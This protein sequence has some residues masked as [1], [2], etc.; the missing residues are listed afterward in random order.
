LLLWPAQLAGSLGQSIL[1]RCGFT[2]VLDLRR[3][4]L[5]NIYAGG[6]LGVRGLDF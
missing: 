4:G 1:A 6:A 2:V 3:S 5:T